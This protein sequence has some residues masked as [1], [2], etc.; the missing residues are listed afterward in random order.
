MAEFNFGFCPD[1]R[2]AEV[3]APD[4][5]TVKDMNGWDYAP[6]PVLPYRRNFK[7]T[8]EGLRWYFNSDGTIDLA[9][10][11]E[12]NAGVLEA[13]YTDHRLFKPFNYDHEWLG[14]LEMR[15]KNPLS[16]PKA[17]PN[18]NGLIEAI[19]FMA[20]HHNPSY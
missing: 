15:F 4:E 19:D 18:S 2:V 14:T 9:T 20:I 7:I 16:V 10:N 6:T 13:F 8:L 11:P 17:L 3:I 12:L 1:T 5:P